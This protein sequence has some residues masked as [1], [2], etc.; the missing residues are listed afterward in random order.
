MYPERDHPLDGLIQPIE[1]RNEA[2]II[3]VFVK[4]P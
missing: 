2:I 4:S 1:W 3:G